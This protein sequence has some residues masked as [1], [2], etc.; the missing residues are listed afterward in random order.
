MEMV[1][2]QLYDSEDAN[3]A[4]SVSAS[5]DSARRETMTTV[6]RGLQN[7]SP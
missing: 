5:F 4:F 2:E 6:G 1:A 7:A 3:N